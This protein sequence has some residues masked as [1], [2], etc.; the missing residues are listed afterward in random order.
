MTP[1]PEPGHEAGEREDP[2]MN[3]YVFLRQLVAALLS[4]GHLRED[5]TDP[6]LAAQTVWAIVHGAAALELCIDKQDKW[7]DFKPRRA[8]FSEALLA[9]VRAM[10][11]DPKVAEKQLNRVL[12][13]S[14]EFGRHK[15]KSRKKNG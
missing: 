2:R 12:E 7:L 11:R 10:F 8:R 3:A 6:D 4:E 1:L 9:L 13:G 15:P 14:P 5:I